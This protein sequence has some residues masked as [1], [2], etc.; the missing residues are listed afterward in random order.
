MLSHMIKILFLEAGE[1]LLLVEG[2]VVA[3]DEVEAPAAEL[4]CI[5]KLRGQ[6][7]I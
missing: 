6:E 2:V 1:A 3:G 5:V 7:E 4:G